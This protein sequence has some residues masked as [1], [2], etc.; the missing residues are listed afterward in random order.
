MT[1]SPKPKP[2]LGRP[3]LL[4]GAAA[5]PGLGLAVAGL[6]HPME[7]TPETAHHFFEMHI[8]LLPVFPLLGLALLLPMAGRKDAFFAAISV[9]VYLYAVLYTAL[10]VLSGIG[11]GLITMNHGETNADVTAFFG[12]GNQ[13]GT[14]GTW[15]FL[16][17]VVVLAVESVLRFRLQAIVPAVVLVAASVSFLSSHIYLWRGVLT[18]LALG[19]ATGWLTWIHHRHAVA[20]R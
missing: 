17:A 10:D 6:F 7:L 11:T 9:L 16:L 4:T 14:A 19:I 8:W 3:L 5:L 15:A 18:V 2:N 20:P 13:L 1:D 12:I